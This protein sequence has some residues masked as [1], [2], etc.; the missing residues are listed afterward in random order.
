MNTDLREMA[1]AIAKE[2]GHA[3][4]EWFPVHGGVSADCKHCRQYICV[5]EPP[6]GKEPILG[7]ASSLRCRYALDPPKEE[8]L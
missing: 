6:N 7:G 8:G 4:G 3:L 5:R 2:L 1:E